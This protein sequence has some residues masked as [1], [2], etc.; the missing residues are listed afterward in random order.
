MPDPLTDKRV[1]IMGL[2]R[3]G[4]ALARWL[5]STG[6]QVAVTDMRTAEQLTDPIKA[7]EGLPISYS[8]GGHPPYVLSG[9]D[10]ICLSGGVPPDLDVIQEAVKLGVGL[11]ND[12]QLF[13]ER[14]PCDVIGITGSAGK[15]T[16]TTLVGKMC[17]KANRLTWVGGNIGNPLIADLPYIKP[18]DIVVMELSS[19]QTEI[20][21]VSP[22]I[23]AI[24]NI[25]PNHLDRH[26]T[27]DAYIEAKARLLDNQV[28]GDVAVLGYDDP[29]TASLAPR[30]RQELAFFSGRVPPDAGAWLVDDRLV[31]RSRFEAPLESVCTI[32]E[33]NLRGYHNVLNTL[34]ACAIAGVAGIPAEAMREAILEFKPVAHRLEVV[35]HVDGVTYINDSIA[36]APER[37]IAALQA[38]PDDMI[39]LLLGGRDKKLPWDDLLQMAVP[40]CRAIITFGEA[41]LMIAEKV[42]QVRRAMIIDMTLEQADSMED[43]VRLASELAYEGDVVLLSPG[44]TSYDKYVDFEERG[45]HFRKLVKML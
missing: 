13:L 4:I 37:V 8:L 22:H 23:A 24:L 20:M 31:C 9:A 5:C 30:V 21:T 28:V 39:V 10:L 26:K 34:A 18:T 43:V 14:C 40:R 27:M 25:T 1:V 33:I 19:F 36:T 17:E 35:R 45:E 2:A 6:A 29:T 44:C 32:S 12:A 15:T 7:L 3:Q 11:S 38:Y 42:D 41:G 16:T